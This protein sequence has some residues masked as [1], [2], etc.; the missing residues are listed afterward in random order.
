MN[1]DAKNAWITLLDS[2][3]LYDILNLD[4]KNDWIMYITGLWLILCFIGVSLGKYSDYLT[5]FGLT[6]HIGCGLEDHLT[7]L[8]ARLILL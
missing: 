7:D 2:E 8:L 4:S 1:L 5:G 6:L 3:Q